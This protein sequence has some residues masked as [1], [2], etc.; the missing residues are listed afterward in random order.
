MRH[1]Y[2]EQPS[3]SEALYFKYIA[4][5]F[6]SLNDVT[7]LSKQSGRNWLQNQ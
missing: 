5:G 1:F 7:T 4:F 3:E 6:L 2:A